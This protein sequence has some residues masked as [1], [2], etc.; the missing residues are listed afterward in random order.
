MY[1]CFSK[2]GCGGVLGVA[3]DLVGGAV[4]WGVA[5][6][7]GIGFSGGG[8]FGGPV[9]VHAQL[10]GQVHVECLGYLPLPAAQPRQTLGSPEVNATLETAQ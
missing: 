7:R 6:R 3:H 8:G 4:F 10:L 2:I 1:I 9:G 5:G